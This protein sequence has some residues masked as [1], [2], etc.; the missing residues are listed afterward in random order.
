[1]LGR[2]AGVDSHNFAISNA[3]SPPS[4]QQA[5]LD[6]QQANQAEE[7]AFERQLDPARVADRIGLA[8]RPGR[9]PRLNVSRED[10]DY[11]QLANT[12]LKQNKHVGMALRPLQEQRGGSTAA[13]RGRRLR[14]SAP[15]RIGRAPVAPSDADAPLRT[16]HPA[17]GKASAVSSAVSAPVGSCGRVFSVE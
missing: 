8:R 6:D 14:A 17:A 5:I 13:V 15:G 7:D 11:I 1:M 10:H 9:K 3:A 2:D 12:L 16:P 4:V